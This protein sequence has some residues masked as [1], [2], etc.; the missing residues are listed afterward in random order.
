MP[1]EVLKLCQRASAAA[2][3]GTRMQLTLLVHYDWCV[4]ASVP[5]FT[6]QPSGMELTDVSLDKA[7]LLGWLPVHA[8]RNRAVWLHVG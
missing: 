2:P 3:V 5:V 8:P 1:D 6:A 4:E 7:M